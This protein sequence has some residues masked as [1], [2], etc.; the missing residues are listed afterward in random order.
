[1]NCERSCEETVIS[2]NVR[3]LVNVVKGRIEDCTERED[4]VMLS[5]RKFMKR[6]LAVGR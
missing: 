5:R 3:K 2:D 1:M 6:C 4:Y